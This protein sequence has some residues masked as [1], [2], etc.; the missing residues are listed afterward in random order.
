MPKYK[1][2]E[3]DVV[4]SKPTKWTAY[5]TGG[6]PNLCGGMWYLYG[7]GEEVKTEIPFQGEPAGTYGEYAT[8]HF[9][10]DWLEQW[11]FYEAGMNCKD[12]CNEYRKWLSTIAPGEEWPQ[13][14]AAFQEQDWRYN[15]CGG[16][17]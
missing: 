6:F 12:W 14:F 9:D 15:S 3:Q 16:C 5:W 1:M 13:I 10:E 2:T 11:E 17:I 4:D 8:W 7:N